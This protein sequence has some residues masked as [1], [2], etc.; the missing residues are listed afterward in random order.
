[1][2]IL[3]CE[4]LARDSLI[5]STFDLYVRKGGSVKSSVI[6]CP[7]FSLSKFGDGGEL[8]DERV[9]VTLRVLRDFWKGLLTRGAFEFPSYVFAPYI[10]R[11]YKTYLL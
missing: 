9:L 2:R 11:L 5:Q 1:L 3:V 8:N 7:H 4:S 6:L 10:L